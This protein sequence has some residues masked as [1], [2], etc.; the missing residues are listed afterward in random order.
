MADDYDY[1]S[2]DNHGEEEE[3]HV[4]MEMVEIKWAIFSMS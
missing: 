4:E 2:V 3:N 1:D